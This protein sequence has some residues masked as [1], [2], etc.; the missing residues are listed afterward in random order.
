MD[1]IEK[2]L[3]ELYNNEAISL[4]VHGTALIPDEEHTE[5]KDICKKGLK[6]RYFDL[7]RT[8]AF[9][10]RGMIHAHGNIEFKNLIHYS[11]G[12]DKKGYVYEEVKEGKMIRAYIREIQLEQISFIVAIPK[13]ME[14][15]DQ[16]AFSE[17]EM[18]FDK[19]YAD[20]PEQLRIGSY[21]EINGKTINPKYIVGFY[22][23][24]D[25]STFMPNSTFYGFKETEKDGEIS[26]EIDYEAIE[27]ENEEVKQKNQEKTKK[28]AQEIGKEVLP[29]V[30]NTK[31]KKSVSQFLKKLVGIKDRGNE[32]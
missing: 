20:T 13:E 8:V 10:D 31:K 27:N 2:I 23:E 1:N 28:R 19:K 26:F 9:Q 4:G 30:E 24:G 22:V 11:Y 32:R 6:C 29:Y 17:S 14:T 16:D 3:E 21:R 18:P 25:I 7:R 5:A 15:I 12:K